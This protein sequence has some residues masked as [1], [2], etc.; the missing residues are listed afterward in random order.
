MAQKETAAPAGTRSGDENQQVGT[1]IFNDLTGRLQY[2]PD[3]TP[4]CR[5]MWLTGPKPRPYG[6]KWSECYVAARRRPQQTCRWFLD[7][8]DKDAV[9]TVR[10]RPKAKA[11]FALVDVA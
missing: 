3:A 2:P 5:C 6:Q 4:C 9:E 1:P 10:A 11:S 7:F 8:E